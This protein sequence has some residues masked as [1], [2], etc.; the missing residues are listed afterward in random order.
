MDICYKVTMSTWTRV[1]MQMRVDRGALHG[2]WHGGYS[3]GHGIRYRA[4]RA[5]GVG[6]AHAWHGAMD[7]PVHGRKTTRPRSL[8]DPTYNAWRAVPMGEHH[9]GP[10]LVDREHCSL[11]GQVNRRLQISRHR[12]WRS[13]DK[14]NR[15]S[16]QPPAAPEPDGVVLESG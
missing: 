2:P 4:R 12:P 5:Q 7:G 3:S 1:D 14:T 11:W 8:I 13:S 16:H 10:Q 9:P 15:S 6:N